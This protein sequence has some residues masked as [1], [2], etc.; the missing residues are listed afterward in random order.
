MI[1]WVSTAVNERYVGKTHGAD[2][3]RRGW[4][5]HAIAAEPSETL[6]QIG[7][8]RALCG[9]APRRG[10]EVDLYVERRCAGCARAADRSRKRR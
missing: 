1:F 5:V 3:G 4:R 2:A 10:W 7:R 6:A 8:R 9:L